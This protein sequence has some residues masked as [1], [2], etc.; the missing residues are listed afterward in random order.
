MKYS[1]PV[2]HDDV[3]ERKI[4]LF[5]LKYIFFQQLLHSWLPPAHWFDNAVP[6]NSY[7]WCFESLNWIDEI[8]TKFPTN[9]I[10]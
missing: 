2:G 4:L 3:I 8:T 5:G 1:V 7:P 9:H 6:L 10:Q